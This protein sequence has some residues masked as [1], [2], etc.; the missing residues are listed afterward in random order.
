RVRRKPPPP[1][2]Q[3]H[4]L[5]LR[6]GHRIQ[7][8]RAAVVAAA[9][10]SV[11]RGIAMA[12]LGHAV[13]RGRHA[14]LLRPVVAARAGDDRGQ[15]A[16]SVGK[17]RA[18]ATDDAA[19]ADRARH[20][21]HCLDRAVH[22]AQDRGKEAFVLQGHPVPAD[23]AGVAAGFRLPQAWHPL[24]NHQ[25]RQDTPVN[26]K[27]GEDMRLKLLFVALIGGA[28]SAAAAPSLEDMVRLPEFTSAVISPGGEYV[29]LAA[30]AGE[31]TGLAIL[32]IR[33]Y[34]KIALK[35]ASKFPRFEH[36]HEMLWA[37]NERVLFTTAIQVG[38]LN[39]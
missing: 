39:Q 37:N 31:Q 26:N 13:R 8:Y 25:V 27:K 18:V 16:G 11:R 21:R 22:R 29:A 14:L 2:Q 19:V 28:T 33:N 6:A 7:P 36:V 4:P 38:S 12:E 34:P 30:P 32:D 1:D 24:L 3:V 10:G 15:R 35:S 5:D 17:S 23:R 20:F 9:P